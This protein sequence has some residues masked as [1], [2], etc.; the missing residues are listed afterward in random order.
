MFITAYSQTNGAAGRAWIGSKKIE[1]TKMG[2]RSDFSTEM[3]YL[4]AVINVR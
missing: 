4:R 3:I 1:V 2:V